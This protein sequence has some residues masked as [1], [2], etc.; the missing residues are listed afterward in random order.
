MRGRKGVQLTV[1]FFR[2]K[3]GNGINAEKVFN[4]L[5]GSCRFSRPSFM[6]IYEG[7]S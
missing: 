2:F 6:N 7:G 1:F 4:L 5:S 3:G